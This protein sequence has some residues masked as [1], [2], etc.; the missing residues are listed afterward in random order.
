MVAPPPVQQPSY[1]APPQQPQGYGP[2]PQQPQQQWSSPQPGPSGG[3]GRGLSVAIGIVAVVVVGAVL[4]GGVFLLGEQSRDS[5]V[6]D[7]RDTPATTEPTQFEDFASVYESVSSGVGQVRIGTCRGGGTGTAFLV[8]PDLAVT[9]YHVVDG[10]T[11]IDV[12]FDGTEV[13]GTVVAAAESDDLALVKLS[14]PVDDGHVFEVAD[15]QPVTG[16]RIAAIGFPLDS[17]KTLTEG[18]VSGLD[19]EIVVSGKKFTGLIQTDTA[20][21]PGNSGGPM[22]DIEGQ[23]IGV[24][25][26]GR[27]DAQGIS[28]VVPS[29][30]VSPTVEM[31]QSPRPLATCY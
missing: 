29:T 8:E 14:E 5:D 3:G 1:G 20:I 21:N 7:D 4:A 15:E 11:S 16:T 22:L 26:A 13:E 17:P 27:L 9:A 12:D 19:R 18:T 24:A 30:K 10:A 31:A 28:F 23:V 6:A 25:D 2:P